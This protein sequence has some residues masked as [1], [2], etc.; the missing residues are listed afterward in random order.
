MASAVVRLISPTPVAG[1][2][3]AARYW[4]LHV[5]LDQFLAA[6]EILRHPSSPPARCR[7]G[8]G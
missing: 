4:V 1:T 3:M 8:R 7:R 5:D 2:A 6:V